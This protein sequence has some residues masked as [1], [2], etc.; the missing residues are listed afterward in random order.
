MKHA[1]SE[2]ELFPSSSSL[3]SADS[4]CTLESCILEDTSEA[5]EE[6]IEDSSF[7][8]PEDVLS[9]SLSIT[10]EIL[11]LLNQRGLR[12]EPMNGESKASEQEQSKAEIK[13]QESV[14]CKLRRSG[15]SEY[16]TETERASSISL[17]EASDVF[18]SGDLTSPDS[19]DEMENLEQ[20]LS[21]PEIPFCVRSSDE[22]LQNK[23]NGELSLEEEAPSEDLGQ[24]ETG[25]SVCKTEASKPEE[26]QQS[27][28]P[29][30][31]EDLSSKLK[32][33]GEGQEVNERQST[34]RCE[35]AP[36]KKEKGPK[37]KRDSTLTPDDRL[38]I[39]RIKNYYD[40][41]DAGASYLSKEDSI[42]YIPTGVVKDSILRFNYILQ[43]EVK[44]DREKGICRTNGCGPEGRQINCQRKPP[45]HAAED[46]AIVLEKNNGGL[47]QEPEYKSC[48]EIR[49][50]W[51]EKEKPNS[52]EVGRVLKRG[53][54]R[55]KELEEKGGE[56]VIVE[57]S[58]LEVVGQLPKESSVKRE[59]GK[60]HHKHNVEDS[61]IRQD[62]PPKTEL[63]CLTS[64]T[65]KASFCSPGM[66]LY[67]SDDICLLE[68]SEKIINKVQLLATMY[69]EKIGRMKTQKKN[70]ESR[71]SAVQNRATVKALPQVLEETTGERHMTEPQ[72]YGH[73]MIHETLLHINCVQENGLCIPAARESLSE[74]HKKETLWSQLPSQEQAPVLQLPE[75]DLVAF[76]PEEESQIEVKESNEISVDVVRPDNESHMNY[77][78]VPEPVPTS[79]CLS[80]EVKTD[81]QCVCKPGPEE[82]RETLIVSVDYEVKEA[83]VL[84]MNDLD[85]ANYSEGS[86]DLLGEPSPCITETQ[87]LREAEPVGLVLPADGEESSNV[88]STVAKSGES[89]DEGPETGEIKTTMELEE[90][91]KTNTNNETQKVPSATSTNNSSAF[92]PHCDRKVADISPPSLPVLENGSHLSTDGSYAVS[93]DKSAHKSSEPAQTQRS[94]GVSPAVMDV[95]QRLQLDSSF[96][97]PYSQDINSSKKLNMATRSSSFKNNTSTAKEFQGM[98]QSNVPI[99]KQQ[100]VA[101]TPGLFSPS[102]LQRKLSRAMALSKSAPESQQVLAK[103]SPIIK[104]RSS[105]TETQTSSIRSPCSVPSPY[106]NSLYSGLVLSDTKPRVLKSKVLVDTQKEGETYQSDSKVTPSISTYEAPHKPC[107]LTFNC[108]KENLVDKVLDGPVCISP[109]SAVLIAIPCPPTIRQIPSSTV[110]EP[111]SRVQSPLTLRSRMFSPPPR[112]NPAG[113]KS[114]HIPSFSNTRAYSFTPLSF[115]YLE[116][117]SSSSAS[118][119]PTC[120]SPPACPW[121]PGFP[122]HSRRSCGNNVPSGGDSPISPGALQYPAGSLNEESRFWCLNR[123]PPCLSPDPTSPTGGISTHELTSIHWPD[124]RELR[125]KYG[126]LKYQKST[127]TEK[128]FDLRP[129]ASFRKCKS[130]DEGPK[131]FPKNASSLSPATS[132][133]PT[134]ATR[135]GVQ[136]CG[137]TERWD[138]SDTKEKAAS[139]A[140]YST[141]VNI[142]IGGSGRIAS[143]S[144]AQVSLTHPLLQAPECLS[145]RKININGSTLEHKTVNASQK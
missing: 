125:T 90:I 65:S 95:M 44:K 51:K 3:Q 18:Y 54:S 88:H 96:S 124:V 82:D 108:H 1:G 133:Y 64:V 102:V 60:D 74:L 39:E 43:Q 140:S 56:L 114:P 137:S 84:D 22:N 118:S 2:G 11:E 101:P 131:L 100:K 77:G 109:G 48:A 144:N 16:Y 93:C 55:S 141:T 86:N 119:T 14:S 9:G 113:P 135:E 25:P 19:V 117:S 66:G 28:F 112:H 127:N 142:Q 8:L 27:V 78:C 4:I 91:S 87:E 58:D 104:S 122:L 98:F 116:R 67:D 31:G 99:K 145:S 121:S 41:A 120:T 68:N 61:A 134:V 75:I 139:R 35:P 36:E 13:E 80:N 92:V 138:S 23:D 126:P 106:R 62:G 72:L 81:N 5:C 21:D 130:L 49:K 85:K 63:T 59:A 83:S 97:V 70:G 46:I 105:D 107:P 34:N 45:S 111:N 136:H 40:N 73:L 129:P 30:D 69:S 37:P 12:A 52:S 76:V 29:G 71:R 57:E 143:F 47:E 132:H 128:K 10:D 115:S 110:S 53:K 7:C 32:E 79:V 26:I 50:A 15:S 20:G 123:S 42:S 6:S 103:R 38:L 24:E 17:E 89:P 33:K 94:R